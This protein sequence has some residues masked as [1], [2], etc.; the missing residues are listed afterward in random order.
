MCS[1]NSQEGTIAFPSL[2]QCVWN[3]GKVTVKA[4]M[5]EERTLAAQPGVEDLGVNVSED[6]GGKS[7]RSANMILDTT[8]IF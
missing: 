4:E 6:L 3:E 7:S 2:L 5:M 1:F 8:A